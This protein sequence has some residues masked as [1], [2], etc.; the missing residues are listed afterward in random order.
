MPQPQPQPEPAKPYL[1]VLARNEICFEFCDTRGVDLPR[2]ALMH[3][4]AEALWQAGNQFYGT[5]QVCVGELD[6]LLRKTE[7]HW[8]PHDECQRGIGFSFGVK[9]AGKTFHARRYSLRPT[10][11]T[12]DLSALYAELT[13]IRPKVVPIKSP[14]LKLVDSVLPEVAPSVDVNVGLAG[15]LRKVGGLNKSSLTFLL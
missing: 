11:D 1:D 14:A 10:S 15:A 2:N 12:V 3:A 6:V 5:Y 13:G 8:L 4:L 7:L 9:E